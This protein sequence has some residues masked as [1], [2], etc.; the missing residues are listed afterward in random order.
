MELTSLSAADTFHSSNPIGH[1][2]ISDSYDR[3]PERSHKRIH[4]ALPLRITYWD[5]EN[6][7][8][9]DRACTYDISTSGARITGLREVK[10]AGEIIVV[11]RGRNRAFCR[12]V[13][14][15]NSDSRLH[16]QVG[17]QS[18]ESERL[19]WET[20]LRDL[21]EAY[22]RIPRQGILFRNFA[23]DIGGRDR[24]LHPRVPVEGQAQLLRADAPL[25][26]PKSS[27]VDLSEFGCLV[28]TNDLPARGTDLKLVLNVGS[29]DFSL[30][31]QVRHAGL[32]SGLG[33]EFR[34][35]RKGDRQALRFLLLK[36]A[37]QEL[38]QSFQ[39][40]LVT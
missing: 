3:S 1:P 20:E 7:P 8:C 18:V 16:G 25:E 19:M 11:E 37:E 10:Q 2:L 6:R 39:L 21:E 14:V 27:L 40:E 22:D 23:A 9:Q 26:P 12:V 30:K 34:E 38:E 29:Y 36:L 5:H 31:G 13:W 4:V 17:I 28:S 33:I 24:R 32:D 35:I 15:G